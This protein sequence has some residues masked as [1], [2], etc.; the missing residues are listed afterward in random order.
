M[1]K[2]ENDI[3]EENKV[4]VKNELSEDDAIEREHDREV[5]AEDRNLDKAEREFN[6]GNNY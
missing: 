2:K 5:K 4:E 6:N 1:S 3:W